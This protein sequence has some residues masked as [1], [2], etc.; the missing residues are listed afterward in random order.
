MASSEPS[1]SDDLAGSGSSGRTAPQHVTPPDLRRLPRTES[2][3][4][5]RIA[6]QDADRATPESFP[7]DT[8]THAGPPARG[9]THPNKRR[10]GRPV[11][12]ARHV[13]MPTVTFGPTAIAT[14]ANALSMGRLLL[15]P[16][17]IALVVAKGPSYV[18]FALGCVLGASDVLDG[19][20]ARRQGATS[21]G[22][23]LD[24]LADKTVVLGAFGALAARA[25]LPLAPI[26]VIA[27]RELAMSA[28]RSV[29]GRRGIS[30]PARPLAKLKTLVQDA[31]IGLALLPPLASDHGVLEGVV[32]AAAAL[33]IVSGA[34][35]VADALGSRRAARPANCDPAAG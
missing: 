1:H 12:P 5:E 28:Y 19:V 25:E 26:V 32:W 24:P 9:H 7:P 34:Q 2:E 8:Q 17:L 35:Y 23:F 3:A 21:S 14:P 11:D 22:A 20:L 10:H 4:S 27:A 31:S 16:A 29:L 33:T 13:A 6:R 30:V 15:A 18:A